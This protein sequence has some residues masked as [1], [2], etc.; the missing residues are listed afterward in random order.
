MPGHSLFTWTSQREA[1]PVRL[2]GGKGAWFHDEEG[3][4]YLDFGSVVF[5]ANAGHNH[6]AILDAM[7]RQLDELAVAGPWM[8]TRVREDA[9]RALAASAPAGLTRFLFT[10]GGADANE[11]AV[12][13]ACQATG[14]RKVVCRTGSYHGATW[15]ALSFSDDPRTRPFHPALPGVVR[16]E[17]PACHRCPWSTSP[18]RCDRP[19]AAHVEEA[20]EREG[21]GQVAAVLMETLAGINGGYFPPADYYARLR[22]ICDRHGILLIL[23]E[24]LTGFGRTGAWFALDHYGARPD[25]VTLGKGITSGHAP[26]GAVAVGERVARHFEDHELMTGLTATAHPVSLAAALGNLQAMRQDDLVGRSRRLGARLLES[27]RELALRRPIVADVR[28]A[29]LFAC[30]EL[31]RPAAAQVKA[32]AWQRR[33]SLPAR[34]RLVF[35]AP[36]LVI[37]DQDLTAGIGLLDAALGSV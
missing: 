21:P 34:G 26:L 4:R 10:L 31:S 14:R 20:I 37:E 27:L 28:G 24:V 33:L 35:V 1:R 32:A 25:M 18:D 7:R 36:P 2:A 30:L 22:R 11:H 13:M 12:K 19:C 9:S 29:G 8:T 16:V 23:D 6:P 17:E 5:N 3:T 15:G